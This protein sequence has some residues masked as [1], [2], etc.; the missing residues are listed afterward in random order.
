LNLRPHEA[1]LDDKKL[2]K[3]SRKLSRRRKSRRINIGMK[4]SKPN[5]NGKEELRKAQNENRTSKKS[6]NAKRSQN[7]KTPP[8]SNSP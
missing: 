7:S 8:E 4:S 1:Q 3:S 2:R 6:S 5:Q